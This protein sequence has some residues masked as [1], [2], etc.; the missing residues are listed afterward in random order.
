MTVTSS[1]VEWIDDIDIDALEADPYPLYERMRS[2]APCV[3][4]P[5]L[6]AYLLTTYDEVREFLA[7]SELSQAP[8]TQ[9]VLERTFGAQNILISNGDVHRDR[10]AS[11]DPPLRRGAVSTYIDELARPIA[12]EVAAAIPGAVS[13]DIVAEY[14][15]PV[16]T[17]GLASML[18]IGDV[19]A[20]VLRRWFHTVIGAASNYTFSDEVFQRSDE[21]VAEIKEVLEPVLVRLETEPDNSGLSHLLH[22]GMPAG[23]LRSRDD[24]YSSFLIE[25]VGGMQEPGHVSATTLLGLLEEGTYGDIVDDPTL[26]PTALAEGLRWVAPVGGV[27]RETTRDA[28]IHDLAIPQ[29]SLVYSMVAS[30]NR[31][32]QKF[33][34]GDRYELHRDGP[35]HMSFGG[36]R[37]FCAGNVFGREL[38]R[39]ALEELTK[40]APR[41][42]LA[43]EGWQMRGWLFRSPQEL[44]VIA[45][46]A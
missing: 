5:A 29:G 28:V 9:P 13:F 37:H 3:F 45:E 25:L 21:V 43:E 23:Q 32:E 18:G 30:A 42:R 34:N 16:S 44:H 12:R 15:E 19:P 41:L 31:D 22:A 2:E 14:L 17:R 24:I 7:D 33:T 6:N 26:I 10:R 39:I 11:V 20:D 36:G 4:V 27:F 38:A 8:A 46:G 35:S 40:V 1:G